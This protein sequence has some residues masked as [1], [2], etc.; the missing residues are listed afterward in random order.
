MTRGTRTVGVQGPESR[1]DTYTAIWL[2]TAA[3]GRLLRED[4][5]VGILAPGAFADIVGFRGDL[6]D[7][8]VDDLPSR[9]SALTVVGGRAVHDPDA[10]FG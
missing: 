7:T 9:Q 5:S 2:Y 3:G 1:V 8:P 6:M 10:L 4:D